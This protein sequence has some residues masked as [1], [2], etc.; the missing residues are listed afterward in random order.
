MKKD[1]KNRDDIILLV[2]R[3]YD[4]VKRDALIGPFFSE[5][6]H[7]NWDKHLLAMYNFWE[8]VV[9]FTG[10][11]EGNPMAKHYTI[12]KIC[13]LQKNHF[14]RWQNL[15]N[16]TVNENFKGYNANNIML[17]AA[18]IGKVMQVKLLT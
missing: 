8:N 13:P 9:F 16:K 12:H 1:I 14:K 3:F 17:R 10:N 18:T 6:I 2:D 5:V 11:Y 7:V 15:F 4:K